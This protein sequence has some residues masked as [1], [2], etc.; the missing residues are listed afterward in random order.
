MASYSIF[1]EK[2]W[3]GE[4]SRFSAKNPTAARFLGVLQEFVGKYAEKTQF[5]RNFRDFV[6]ENTEEIVQNLENRDEILAEVSNFIDFL[7]F[8][9]ISQRLL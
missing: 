3:C 2:S 4:K 8:S 1:A 7:N 6:A 5:S 9:A